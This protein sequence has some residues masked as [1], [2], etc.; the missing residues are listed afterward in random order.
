MNFG[1][2]GF[3]HKVAAHSER[4][5]NVREVNDDYKMIDYS[6]DSELAIELENFRWRGGKGGPCCSRVSQSTRMS[7]QA[8]NAK[9]SVKESIGLSMCRVVE[10]STKVNW[11][12]LCYECMEEKW[13]REERRVRCKAN[14]VS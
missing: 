3:L 5:L 11:Y 4:V 10:Q 13:K 2:E 7:I 12:S 14:V 8:S 1:I 9:E 6:C